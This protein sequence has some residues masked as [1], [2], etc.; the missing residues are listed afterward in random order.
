MFCACLRAG[1]HPSPSSPDIFRQHHSRRDVVMH[2]QENFAGRLAVLVLTFV[3]GLATTSSA[4]SFKSL[5]SFDN[6]NGGIPVYM[7]LIEGTDGNF[8]G[9]TGYG[10]TNRMGTVFK[11]NATG[12]LTSLYNFCGQSNCADGAFSFS[13]LALG[14]GGNFYGTTKLGG[15]N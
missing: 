1:A 11:M 13:S 10:G 6:T 4:Q 15:E 2:N 9:T 5:V 3:V 8:Y 7:S 14:R 12:A